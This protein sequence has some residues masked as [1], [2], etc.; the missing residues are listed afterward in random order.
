MCF[1]TFP[2]NLAASS[3]VPLS[4][5]S[6]RLPHFKTNVSSASLKIP[7]RNKWLDGTWF[8]S[9]MC[10]VS[11]FIYLYFTYFWTVANS[12]KCPLSTVHSEIKKNQAQMRFEWY[13]KATL[14]GFW[15][16]CLLR[17]KG[18]LALTRLAVRRQEKPLYLY[19]YLAAFCSFTACLQVCGSDRSSL[20]YCVSLRHCDI[21]NSFFVVTHYFVTIIIFVTL[22]Y[23]RWARMRSS[24]HFQL[25]GLL[26]TDAFPRTSLLNVT[27]CS[28]MGS[29]KPWL[30]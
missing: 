7:R 30:T 20:C 10:K 24:S 21:P 18:H 13:L 6:P 15:C 9:N 2:I 8:I 25:K 1:L 26:R 12:I 3:N 27:L 14:A 17:T 19:L 4:Y 5:Q 16:V 23:A 22:E 28:E 29:G 11:V